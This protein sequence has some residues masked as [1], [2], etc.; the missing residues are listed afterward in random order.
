MRVECPG[1]VS[2]DA[3]GAPLCTDGV[4]AVLA[5][6]PVAEFDPADIDNVTAGQA[7]T[8][9]FVIVATGWAI[10]RG[11]KYVLSMLS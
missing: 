4:S 2:T 5:W 1:V 8:A 6:E 9:G 10:G 3:S 11:F 7:F